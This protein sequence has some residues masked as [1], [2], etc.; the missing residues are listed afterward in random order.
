[1]HAFTAL[2]TVAS[3]HHALSPARLLARLSLNQLDELPRVQQVE[4]VVAAA[5]QLAVNEDSRHRALRKH[6]LRGE[7]VTSVCG[8][9]TRDGNGV[10]A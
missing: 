6:V 1:M 4:T 10:R 7:A 2:A 3:A 8:V 5:H 9:A